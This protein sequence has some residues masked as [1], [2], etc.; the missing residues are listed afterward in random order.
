MK[1]LRTEGEGVRTGRTGG[2]NARQRL[3]VVHTMVRVGEARRVWLPVVVVAF[4][5]VPAW[6]HGF[7][8]Y[9]LATAVL[10][11]IATIGMHL[12]VVRTGQLSIAQGAVFGVG[13]YTTGI[14]VGVHHVDVGLAIVLGCLTGAI[15]GGLIGLPSLRLSSHYLA[16][17]TLMGAVA[18]PEVVTYFGGLTHGATGIAV[19]G[20]SLAVVG[21][22]NPTSSVYVIAAVIATLLMVV[23]RNIGRSKLGRAWTMLRVDPVTART[24]G[25]PVGLYRM[26]AFILAGAVGGISGALF[27]LQTGFISPDSFSYSVSIYFLVG[28]VLGGMR[29]VV[30]A[31]IGGILMVLI[32]QYAGSYA[33][34]DLIVFGVVI[35][36][37]VVALRWAGL[38]VA[39]R[40][41]A[42]RLGVSFRH[43][44]GALAGRAAATGDRGSQVLIGSEADGD[45]VA[46]GV[47]TD[48]VME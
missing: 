1:A 41:L 31:F 37:V 43:T 24:F 26:L 32:P 48:E 47:L 21:L 30:G 8:M 25:V 27:A 10:Y 44:D 2:K 35:L 42:R 5:T 7:F 12:L 16:L 39:L 34:L 11:G 36:V 28:V 23:D 45:I 6:L 22:R 33:G 9:L 20:L 18:F 15:A 19:P 38:Q 14:L 4:V 29:S 46:S 3:D 17:V 40:G 13:A